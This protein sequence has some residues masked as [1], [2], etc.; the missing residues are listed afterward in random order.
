VRK[1]VLAI[2]SLLFLVL[3]ASAQEPQQEPTEAAAGTDRLLVAGEN[4]LGEISLEAPIAQFEFSSETGNP[5]TLTIQ[6]MSPDFDP[7]LLVYAGENEIARQSNPAGLPLLEYAFTPSANTEY[8]AYI[9]GADGGMGEFILSMSESIAALPAPNELR[10]GQAIEDLVSP[11]IPVRRYQFSSS[12]TSPMLVSVESSLSDGGPA[13]ILADSE[14]EVLGTARIRLLGGT[15]YI[16]QAAD[17]LY[18]IRILHSGAEREEPFTISLHALNASASVSVVPTT[19]TVTTTPAVTGTPQTANGEVIIAFDGPCSL[20]PIGSQGVNIRSG[21]G[22]SF[23]IIEG[24]LV[25]EVV[26][27]A[28]HDAS[29]AWWQVEYSPSLFGWVA[30]G[31]VRLGGDCADVGLAE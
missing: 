4:R 11:N 25:G 23:D 31:A 10:D 8:T 21:P 29:D 16:P 9:L 24:V 20:T 28:G 18:E 7:V 2:W 3:T 6:S 26:R 12:R 1:T 5:L 17:V 19:A 13:L 22:E 14:G 27:V 15:F 30:A